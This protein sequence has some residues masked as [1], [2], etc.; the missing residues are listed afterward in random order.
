MVVGSLGNRTDGAGLH[1]QSKHI[2]INIQKDFLCV[3]L[4][5][6]DYLCLIVFFKGSCW[7]SFVSVPQE[8]KHKRV[9]AVFIA[10][11]LHPCSC[12]MLKDHAA[13]TKGF[14][15]SLLQSRDQQCGEEALEIKRKTSGYQKGCA[16]GLKPCRWSAGT[17]ALRAIVPPLR[18]Y[19]AALLKGFFP[20]MSLIPC[21]IHLL[22][23]TAS[24]QA[25]SPQLLLQQQLSHL[26]LEVKYHLNIQT[27]D[28]LEKK[29][30]EALRWYWNHFTCFCYT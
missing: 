22:Q 26:P 11:E 6:L 27:T 7:A 1:F 15:R 21:K 3:C 14:W 18:G 2:K 4:C 29:A 13:F 23:Q 10:P 28:Y 19:K 17:G 9:S 30:H 25:H 20:K 24:L 16:P 8:R 12:L 5:V